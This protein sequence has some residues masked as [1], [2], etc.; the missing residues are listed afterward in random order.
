MAKK[1]NKKR[2]TRGSTQIRSHGN[3]TQVSPPKVRLKSLFKVFDEI[4]N[5]CNKS[6]IGT[7]NP[8]SPIVRF[9]A[10]VLLRGLNTLRSIRILLEQAHWEL[11]SAGARQLFELLVNME[12]LNSRPD[13]EEAS[14]RY[15]KFGL[16]Q[17]TRQQQQQLEYALKTGRTVNQTRKKTIDRLLK[18]NFPEF[19]GKDGRWVSSWSGKNTRQLAEGSTRDIR[20]D[21]YELLFSAWSEQTHASPGALLGNIFS[22]A[23]SKAIE[24]IVADDD[25]EI[26]EVAGVSIS[27]F[28]ELWWALPNVVPLDSQTAAGW[29][30]KFADEARKRG[31]P[32][33]SQGT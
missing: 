31:A 21:Q 12:H 13:R 29:M 11:A 33:P 28:F 25:R 3:Q 24:E 30:E 32:I 26:I 15:S 5:G 23:G 10:A 8:L 17:M 18:E 27:L 1:K 19:L 20:T 2:K 16:M 6:L 7:P 14:L 22:L 4:I 9:D